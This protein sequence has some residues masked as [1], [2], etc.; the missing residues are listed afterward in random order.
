M[1]DHLARW[2]PVEAADERVS[3]SAPY[4]FRYEKTFGVA[5]A[6][7]W[8]S[9]SCDESLAARSST[10]NTP[11]WSGPRP[12]G[13]GTP[14]EVVLAPGLAGVH[15]RFFRCDEGDRYSFAVYEPNLPVFRTFAADHVVEP[16]GPDG[17]STHFLAPSSS[18][19]SADGPPT[20]P[21]PGDGNSPRGRS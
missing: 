12:L 4:A 2:H 16:H 11:N 7:T 10:V 13:V 20:S 3:T 18:W 1:L 21:A 14:R 9:L 6:A 19:P 5:R 8:E 15:G 17:S